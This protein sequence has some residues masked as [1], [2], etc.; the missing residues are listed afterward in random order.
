MLGLLEDLAASP[1]TK[2]T[3]AAEGATSG[4]QAAG[5]EGDSSE[6]EAADDVLA[7][8][9]ARERV[10]KSEDTTESFDT[11]VDVDGDGGEVGDRAVTSPAPSAGTQSDSGAYANSDLERD[12]SPS[13]V[14]PRYVSHAWY[15]RAG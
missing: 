8:P 13:S 10:S 12:P 6:G 9:T 15:R 1:S 5:V 3:T 11:D 2:Q 14:I 4:E 7:L